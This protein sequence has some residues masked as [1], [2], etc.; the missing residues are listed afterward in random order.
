MGFWAHV[1][2][3]TTFAYNQMLMSVVKF[4][5]FTLPHCLEIVIWNNKLFYNNFEMENDFANYL[6][7]SCW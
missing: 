7:E 1:G 5:I 2:R 4:E 3:K 6:K